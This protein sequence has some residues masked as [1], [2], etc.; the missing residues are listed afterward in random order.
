MPM[1]MF[2]IAK[3]FEGCPEKDQTLCFALLHSVTDCGHLTNC[4]LWM[5]CFEEN[6]RLLCSSYCSVNGVEIEVSERTLV[7]PY[8]LKCESDG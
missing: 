1:D 3:A 2:S 5:G 7:H 4:E 6:N 8:Q